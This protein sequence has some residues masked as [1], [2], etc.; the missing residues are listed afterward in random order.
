M[1]G[2]YLL[3]VLV[4]NYLTCLETF[5]VCGRAGQQRE[6][7][8]DRRQRKI[9]EL[10]EELR[11]SKD[12]KMAPAEGK[13]ALKQ[14]RDTLRDELKNIGKVELKSALRKKKSKQRTASPILILT[15]LRC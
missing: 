15:L 1:F 2:L 6:G 12:W 3:Q 4:Q 14:L 13:A 8:R 9:R 11:K 7:N 10:R 5:G